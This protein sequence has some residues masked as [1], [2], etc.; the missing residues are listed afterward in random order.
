MDQKISV[1]LSQ[2]AAEY[3]GK[4]QAQHGGSVSAVVHTLIEGARGDR[5]PPDK[6]DSF[7][8]RSDQLLALIAELSAHIVALL[9]VLHPVV[10]DAKP[11]TWP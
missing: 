2:P 5:Q 10:P 9:G 4:L 3:V 8:E 1:R 7:D 11:H 6:E